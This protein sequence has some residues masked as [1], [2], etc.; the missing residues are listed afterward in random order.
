MK[1]GTQ[2]SIEI[3]ENGSWT[4]TSPTYPRWSASGDD[5]FRAAD[6]VARNLEEWVEKNPATNTRTD[7]EKKG[8]SVDPWRYYL[9]S[10]M[11]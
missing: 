9:H 6:K 4:A 5:E 10:T 1:L 7:S 11:M 8:S 3:D 2:I